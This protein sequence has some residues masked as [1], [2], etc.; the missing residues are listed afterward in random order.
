MDRLEQQTNCNGVLQFDVQSK[1]ASRYSARFCASAF[2]EL[3]LNF[4]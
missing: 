1:A 4:P 2:S 3:L